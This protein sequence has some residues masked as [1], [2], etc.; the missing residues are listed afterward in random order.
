MVHWA[1]SLSLSSFQ[2]KLKYLEKF[3]CARQDSGVRGSGRPGNS[4]VRLSSVSYTHLDVYKRQSKI[5]VRV[6]SKNANDA[7]DEAFWRRRLEHAWNY[8]KTVL[9]PQD[10][11]CCR[12]IFGEADHFPGLTVDRFG[13][14]PVSYTH[15]VRP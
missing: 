10:L 14:L 6:F 1:G 12:V 8:R 5:R 15:L 4:T 9:R 7:F 13:P 3:G 11:S 2:I